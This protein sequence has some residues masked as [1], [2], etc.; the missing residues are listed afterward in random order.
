MLQEGGVKIW[1]PRQVRALMPQFGT[2]PSLMYSRRH[3][4]L[5]G[6]HETG[7]RANRQARTVR[8]AKDR[9][10]DRRTFR[11]SPSRVVFSLTLFDNNVHNTE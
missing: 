7:L 11:V 8:L 6:P 4:G 10:N 9:G 2:S 1:R 5:R 3:S